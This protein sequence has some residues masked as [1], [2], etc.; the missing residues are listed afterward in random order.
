MSAVGLRAIVFAVVLL[1]P[2]AALAQDSPKRVLVFGDSLTWGWTPVEP[3]VPTTRHEPADRWTT[4]LGDALGDGY[5]LVVEGLSGRTTNVDD[6]NDVKLNGADYLPA[7]LASHEPLDLVIILLGTN[8]TKTYLDRTPFE[9]G[10]GMGELI[11]IVQESPGWDWTDYPTPAV[12]VIS[13]PPLGE[14]IAPMAADIFAGSRAKSEA[15][16]KVYEAI[17]AAGGAGFF[18]AGTV[19]ETDGVDGIHFTAATNATL[20]TAVAAEVKALLGD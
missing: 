16:P 11:N 13:P 18:D 6:P 3:I 7:A 10:L 9:I 4:A 19:I 17:A 5:T 2:V 20:G 14:T 1:L 15:L 8:D 12:L